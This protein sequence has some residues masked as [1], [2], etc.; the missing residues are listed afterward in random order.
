MIRVTSLFCVNAM[1]KRDHS[2]RKTD[3]SVNK[4]FVAVIHPGWQGDTRLR[5][6]AAVSRPSLWFNPTAQPGRAIAQRRRHPTTDDPRLTV[7]RDCIALP[8]LGLERSIRTKK[9]P[10]GRRRTGKT[11]NLAY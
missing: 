10:S 1:R 4:N 5:P 3:W 11:I 9:S 6:T 8:A 7:L 2:Y